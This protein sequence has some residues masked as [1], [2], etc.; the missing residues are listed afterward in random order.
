MFDRPDPDAD[1]GVLRAHYAAADADPPAP[2]DDLDVELSLGVLGIDR[3]ADLARLFA[4][5]TGTDASATVS[6]LVDGHAEIFAVD[7]LDAHGDRRLVGAFALSCRDTQG[8]LIAFVMDRRAR[9]FGVERFLVEALADA[10]SSRG[11]ES[12]AVTEDIA[13]TDLALATLLVSVPE[14]DAPGESPES[15]I[16]TSRLVELAATS[17]RRAS[18]ATAR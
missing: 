11:Y 6:R 8:V 13:R 7:L 2:S 10:A 15:W 12:I 3:H 4:R 9:A 1:D 18:R 5:E 17:N 16:A 14:A